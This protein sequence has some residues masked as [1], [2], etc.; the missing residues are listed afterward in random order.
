[1]TAEILIEFHTRTPRPLP[2]TGTCC[3]QHHTGEKHA[4]EK[5]TGEKYTGEKHTGEKHT[6]ENHTADNQI[7]PPFKQVDINEIS[8][9][10]NQMY[11]IDCLT[12][13]LNRMDTDGSG[14]KSERAFSTT[15]TSYSGS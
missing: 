7:V 8:A 11:Q 10:T 12:E 13:L 15:T 1:M 6:G 3:A 4:G 14:E 2:H 9:F 5:H